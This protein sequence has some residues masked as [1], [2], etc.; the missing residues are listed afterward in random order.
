MK[1]NG[2]KHIPINAN[3]INKNKKK[4]DFEEALKPLG[5]KEIPVWQSVVSVNT[6]PQ[7]I[8]PFDPSSISGL[9]IWLDAD[10]NTTLEVIGGGVQSW[11]SKGSVPVVF[12]AS[13]SARRPQ[14]ITTGNTGSSSAVK[15]LSAATTTDRSSL[16]TDSNSSFS[17]NFGYTQFIIGK[18]VDGFAS[19]N[20]VYGTV[21]GITAWNNSSTNAFAAKQVQQS[22]RVGINDSIQTGATTGYVYAYQNSGSLTTPISKVSPYFFWGQAVNYN[23]M[24][25]VNDNPLSYSN[26]LGRLKN[27]L[28]TN[29]ISTFSGKTFNSYGLVG[30][31][32]TGTESVTIAQNTE[33][34]EILF[35][36]RVLTQNEFDSVISYLENKWNIPASDYSQVAKVNVNWVGKTGATN[37]TLVIQQVSPSQSFYSTQFGEV[38]GMTVMGTTSTN[39]TFTKTAANGFNWLLT[40][41]NGYTVTSGDCS[42]TNFSLTLSAGTYNLTGETSYSCIVPS[43]TPTPTATITPTPT[44]T[45]TITPTPTLTMTPTPSG[46]PFD[47]DAAAYLAAVLSAGGTGIT[48]TVSAA[49]NTLYTSLKSAGVY[50]KL[51]AFYPI[52][53]GVQN[54]HA[55]DGKTPGGSQTLTFAGSW[56]HTDK[57][58]VPTVCNTSN[59]ADTQYLPTSLNPNSNHMFGYFNGKGSCGGSTY[60]GAGPSPYFILGHPAFEFFSSNAVVSGVG[61]FTNYGALLGTRTAS[62]LTKAFR[63]IDGGAWGSGGGTITTAPTT[64]PSNSITIAKVNGSGFPSGERYAFF[65]FGDGLSDTEGTNYYNAVLAFQTS[66]SRNTNL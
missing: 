51:I 3:I 60:D 2:R 28:S 47:A 37:D 33:F 23:S 18:A 26:V 46:T 43:P 48:P 10:D 25:P 4:F 54:S 31:K 56:T 27:T 65:S 24:F 50:S 14:Y 59:Y 16:L 39:Y 9:A 41:E 12:S 36:N 45:T 11:T 15:F 32:L 29:T 8:T 17:T 52:L 13:T 19:A 1:W 38:S 22:T 64:Y 66:L 62:N 35:Y 49:T 20:Q 63:S 42:T 44:Q 21:N 34:Y 6:S 7:A 57:G 53:G 58:M 30:T 5:Q 61:T 40:D 55:V